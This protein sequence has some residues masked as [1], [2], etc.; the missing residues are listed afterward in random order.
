MVMKISV[1]EINEE[2]RLLSELAND[3][4]YDL[5]TGEIKDNTK[6][7]LELLEEINIKKES[8]LENIEYLKKDLLSKAETLKSEENRLEK[9]RKS[10]E[11]NVSRLKSLQNELLQGEK[12]KT[13]KFTFF[14]K[15]SESVEIDDLNK[16][17]DEGIYIK[18]KIEPDKTS[19]KKALKDGVDI[20]GVSLKISNN[21]NVR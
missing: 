6:E 1:F 11:R 19:I 14:Y 3:L 5:E 8:K 16:L 21:L 2:F 18:T 20:K 17:I 4:D 7:L 9:R 13:D 10:L 12:C 15:K